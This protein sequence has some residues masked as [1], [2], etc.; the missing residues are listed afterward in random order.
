[1]GMIYLSNPLCFYIKVI[2]LYSRNANQYKKKK[3][4][5]DIAREIMRSYNS[6]LENRKQMMKMKPNLKLKLKYATKIADQ[7]KMETI[8][9]NTPST[10]P[11]YK[12]QPPNP[13]S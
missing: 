4:K 3:K 6:S 11:P 10:K 5:T 13:T 12:R 1:M 9:N 7:T 2:R 8:N